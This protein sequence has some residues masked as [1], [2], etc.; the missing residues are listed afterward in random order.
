MCF[1]TLGLRYGIHLLLEP[2]WSVLA[3]GRSAL[4][5][6]GGRRWGQRETRHS[7]PEAPSWCPA[8]VCSVLFSLP[9]MRCGLGRCSHS[10]EFGIPLWIGSPFFARA[11]SQSW[12]QTVSK[13]GSKVLTCSPFSHTAWVWIVVLL[14]RSCAPVSNL[15]NVPL[16]QLAAPPPPPRFGLL[17]PL[18]PFSPFLFSSF[19]RS[20]YVAQISV[21]HVICF[22]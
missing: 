2:F 15:F 9:S 5:M 14:F 19:D 11:G 7:T 21:K 1:S 17:S 4:A 13:L 3:L 16:P 18:A 12:G 10:T 22:P 8:L 6:A 20:H